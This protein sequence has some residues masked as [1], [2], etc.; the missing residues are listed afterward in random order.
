MIVF[1]LRAGILSKVAYHNSN[2]GNCQNV[3]SRSLGLI[4]FVSF[5]LF[6]C[7]VGQT[8]VMTINILRIKIFGKDYAS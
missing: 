7:R 5:C 8:K 2:G 3:S 6:F 1:A 4:W